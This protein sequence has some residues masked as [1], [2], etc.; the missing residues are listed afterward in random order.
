MFG[1]AAAA[2]LILFGGAALA[3]EPQSGLS[4]GQNKNGVFVSGVG[5]GSFASTMGFKRDDQ[6]L[7]YKFNETKRTVKKTSDI[8]ELLDR[9]NGKYTVTVKGKDGKT[10]KI[11]G[12]IVT[13]LDLTAT[14]S[15]L[16]LKP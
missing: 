14:K 10:R 8:Q 9:T 1:R 16:F 4:V 3:E 2:V 5:V 6:I 11:E 13:K 15:L 12:S 7:E